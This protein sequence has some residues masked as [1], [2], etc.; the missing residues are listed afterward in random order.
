MNLIL[1]WRRRCYGLPLCVHIEIDGRGRKSN[2]LWIYRII[3]SQYT[4]ITSTF[5]L[6]FASHILLKLNSQTLFFNLSWMMHPG[7][8]QA[9]P[10]GTLVIQLWIR[11]DGCCSASWLSTS[12]SPP[13]AS[14]SS[15]EDSAA[16]GLLMVPYLRVLVDDGCAKPSC[17]CRKMGTTILVSRTVGGSYVPEVIPNTCFEI[18]V[19]TV[20]MRR[21]TSPVS[22]PWY[23]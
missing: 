17:C 7:W 6:S 16:I 15:A 22:S 23:A 1:R 13:S 14:Y 20:G 5:D 21:L 2:M 9:I 12:D 10:C 4:L 11:N 8:R 19:L 18:L 3:I